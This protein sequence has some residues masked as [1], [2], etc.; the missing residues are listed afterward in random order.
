[1]RLSNSGNARSK[2][3]LI[4]PT[5]SLT[6]LEWCPGE[7]FNRLDCSKAQ[8]VF[9]CEISNLFPYQEYNVCNVIYAY[10]WE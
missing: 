6:D 7:L 8:M 9:R 10:M 2:Q 4:I 1:M 5:E 3:L